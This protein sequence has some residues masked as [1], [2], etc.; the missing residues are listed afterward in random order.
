MVWD[1]VPLWM[2]QYIRAHFCYG[3]QGND[4]PSIISGPVSNK[5]GNREQ[6]Y[7][8]GLA[9]CFLNRLVNFSNTVLD[10]KSNGW[11]WP[12]VE[13]WVQASTNTDWSLIVALT[14]DQN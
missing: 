7:V 2:S 10:Y 12:E 8:A 4:K 13:R 14:V 11:Y 6:W 1:V 5:P 3:P 9:F